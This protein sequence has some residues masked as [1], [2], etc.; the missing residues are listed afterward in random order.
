[1]L[2]EFL[3]SAVHAAGIAGSFAFLRMTGLIFWACFL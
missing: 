2:E 1:M 3:S